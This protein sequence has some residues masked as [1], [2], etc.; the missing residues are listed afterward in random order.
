MTQSSQLD[1]GRE[2]EIVRQRDPFLGA[3][4]QRIIDSVNRF[5]KNAGVGA[6]GPI[7]A[8][9]PV[10]NTQVKGTLTSNVLTAPGEILHWVHEHNAPLQ[11]GIQYVTEIATDAGFSNAHPVDA[12]S[13]RSG[14]VTLPT[15]DDLGNPVGY[16]L[17]V[18]A[19]MPGGVPSSPTV[20]GG[21]QGPTKIVMGGTTN[22]TLLTSQSGGTA[23]PG[24]GGQ[25]LGRFSSRPAVGGPKRNVRN[26][27]SN[28]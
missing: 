13:S 7:P 28:S 5:A 3:F 9:A 21:L 18:M 8:P 24:Q 11:R 20:Y 15:N 27:A 12:G 25:A 6:I 19:Q 14:F 4:L 1:G 10:D 17:R 22:M 16:Y 2:L 23:A 26:A